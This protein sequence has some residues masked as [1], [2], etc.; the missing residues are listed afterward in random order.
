VDGAA[1]RTRFAQLA[2]RRMPI[3]PA[4]ADVVAPAAAAD[5]QLVEYH[6]QADD[7]SSSSHD[8]KFLHIVSPSDR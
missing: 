6:K 2:R 4:L 3:G 8:D 5:C 7:K 1:T